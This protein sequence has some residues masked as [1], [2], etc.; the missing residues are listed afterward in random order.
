MTNIPG[1]PGQ[2]PS[3]YEKW[4]P[5]F[6]GNN[7]VSIED[8]T[9]DLWAFFQPHPISDDVEYLTM[10]LF[11]A[12]LYDGA[13]RWYNGLPDASI[14]SMDKLKEVFLKRWS[15]KED[16]NM[17]LIRLNRI[18]K[19]ENEIVREFH[20]KF[21]RLIQQIP[22]SHHPSSNFLL[23]LYTKD[24]TGQIG[25]LLRNKAP[26]TIQE[27]HEMATKIEDNLSLSRVEPFST[28]RVKMDAKPK[29]VHND[30]SIS[31]IGASLEKIQSTIDGM[32][33]T[34]ELMM[35]RIVNLER[36]Q[37]Q[38]PRHPYKG[39]FQRGN[40]GFKLKNDQEVPNTLAPTNVVE[41][42]PWCLQCKESH[43]EHECP[44]K[45]W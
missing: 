28:P 29:V 37:Q 26:R 6:T 23:F 14:T 38:A 9:R 19:A 34:Q 17:L 1:Y 31:D 35:N 33:K 32:V 10:E 30:E 44:I 13:R 39:Q 45:K 20:D 11:S 15:V 40:Q 4:L 42:N 8:H 22:E 21:E 27:A 3:R 24:F 16:P 18:T 7:V 43:W 25:F 12:T 36:A 2:I 5:K 41:E